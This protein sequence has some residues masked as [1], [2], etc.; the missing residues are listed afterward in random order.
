MHLLHLTPGYTFF[1]Y[2][3]DSRQKKSCNIGELHQLLRLKTDKHACRTTDQD[4]FFDFVPCDTGILENLL[5][6]FHHLVKEV[7][8]EFLELGASQSL[9]EVVS[10]LERFKFEAGGLLVGVSSPGLLNLAIELAH[11]M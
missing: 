4:D 10:I 5:D 11:G 2:L 9:G 8:V 3:N 7:R 1:K 6:T